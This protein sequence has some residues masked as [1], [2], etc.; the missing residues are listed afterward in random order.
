MQCNVLYWHSFPYRKWLKYYSYS[1]RKKEEL[2]PS[3][4]GPFPCETCTEL[5]KSPLA[6]MLHRDH[7]KL[8]DNE[9]RLLCK[10]SSSPRWFNVPNLKHKFDGATFLSTWIATF[11][12]VTSYLS[13]HVHSIIIIALQK[14]IRKKVT[15][16]TNLISL[17]AYSVLDWKICQ[18]CQKSLETFKT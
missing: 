4:A 15:F 12:Y 16:R 17:G 3:E 8:K 18:S 5:S 6:Y 9:S 1:R 11:R 2:V 10:V 7:H 13:L 14:R